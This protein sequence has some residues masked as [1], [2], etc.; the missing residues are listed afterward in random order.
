MVRPESKHRNN[1]RVQ[2]LA[3][4]GG[5]NRV[6][7]NPPTPHF[8]R[9]FFIKSNLVVE[10]RRDGAIYP[11]HIPQ[12]RTFLDYKLG[13]LTPVLPFVYRSFRFASPILLYPRSTRYYKQTY[14]CS[15]FFI[16]T[17]Q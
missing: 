13:T 2:P 3:D 11:G 8:G 17:G 12:T 7:G 5:V 14:S 1:M 4:P 9:I 10:K 15:V 6:A 16:S